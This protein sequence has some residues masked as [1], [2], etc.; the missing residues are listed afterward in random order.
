[1]FSLAE[2]WGIRADNPTK[3]VAK[4]HEES[5]E[6]YLSP[7]E[8]ERL[9]RSLVDYP[10]KQVA[11]A[12]MLALLTGARRSEVVQAPW[13][14]FDLSQG[15]WIKPSSH[16]KQ[17]KT[18]RVPLSPPALQLMKA[19]R[20][21]APEDAV[22]V[23]PGRLPSK[24]RENVRRPWEAIRKAAGLDDVRFHDLRHS[25]ASLLIND[26]VS[27]PI[28]GRL[29]GHSHAKTTMRYAHLADDPLRAA[30]S[31]VGEKIAVAQ[32]RV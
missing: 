4:N 22:Y 28:I 9:M 23:F 20:E 1:M 5:R 26:G 17:K 3:G 31:R 7:T 15:V 19:M 32:R 21:G 16:T 14:Q 12:I 27:L 10:D 13:D 8:L 24:P 11:N 2:R 30:T 18:H 6:R 25:Y 29:L